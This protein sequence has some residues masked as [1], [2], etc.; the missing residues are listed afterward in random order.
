M[1]LEIVPYKLFLVSDS[2]L[3]SYE[4]LTGSIKNLELYSF[5]LA[6]ETLAHIHLNPDFLFLIDATADMEKIDFLEKIQEFSPSTQFIYI[7]SQ[8]DLK[9]ALS[10]VKKGAKD[11]INITDFHQEYI[12]KLLEELSGTTWY[13]DSHSKPSIVDKFREF[14][15][16]GSGRAMRNLYRKM[17]DLARADSPILISGE[18]GCE[19]ELVAETIHLLSRRQNG[20][21]V[22]F[23]ALSYP[24][25]LL[26]FEIFGREKDIFSGILKRKIGC[27]EM[28]SGGSLYFENIDA[29]P[30]HLQSRIMR[31]LKEKKFIKPGGQNIVFWNSRLM[32]VEKINF[33]KAI[34]NGELREDLYHYI[35]NTNI[36]IP[37]LR[38]R[39]QDV[40]SIANNIL[41]EF[42]RRNKLKSLIFTQAAKEA[43]TQYP[44]HGN[45]QEMKTII[46]ASA[47]FCKGN[48]IDKDDLIFQ[49]KPLFENWQAEELT[50]DEYIEKIIHSFLNKY[51]QN[52]LLVAKKLNIGK[53]TI[54][55]LLS[56]DKNNNKQ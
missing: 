12:N 16:L 11:Y 7:S 1:E 55:R 49:Q 42:L 5:K 24:A 56:K 2:D 51:D 9:E 33:D 47:L 36:Q 48:E 38:T 54:Y 41:R 4:N 32:V 45:L 25:E 17:E 46:E 10:L 29:L 37:A 19:H 13:S 18:E 22:I 52:V 26:E 53:S 40:L 39:K 20:P 23:D 35:K 15:F 3:R 34:K 31:A 27:I 50:M 30:I 43:L 14:G 6:H 21:F 8:P 44:Y 28:A